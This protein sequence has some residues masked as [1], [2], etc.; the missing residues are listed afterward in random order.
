MPETT[1]SLEVSVGMPMTRK[2][3]KKLKDCRKKK[4][5]TVL[6]II[7]TSNVMM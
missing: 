6:S 5:L 7:V 3:G 1:I 2:F 4:T